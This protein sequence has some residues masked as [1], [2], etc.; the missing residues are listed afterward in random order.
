MSSAAPFSLVR[1]NAVDPPQEQQNRSQATEPTRVNPDLA[2]VAP[3]PIIRSI[4]VSKDCM[5]L[6]YLPDWNF[7]NVDNLGIG[8]N[9]GGV[10]TLLDW[11]AVPPDEATS[12]ERRFLI[13]IYARETISHPPAS[14]ICVHEILEAWPERTSWRTKPSYADEPAAR[15][16]FE[17]G[18]GWKL[19]DVTAIIRTR[20]KAAQN[21]YGVVLRFSKEDTPGGL[22]EVF[23]DYKLVSREGTGR[24]ADYRPILLVVKVK[25]PAKAD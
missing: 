21:G 3:G 8:N 23:S 25:E 6:S 16:K 11:P 13:A 20:A 22:P 10:R 7:G 24:W 5:V 15:G 4:P 19:F 17:P 9:D 1:A 2:K 14:A 12:P 18:E